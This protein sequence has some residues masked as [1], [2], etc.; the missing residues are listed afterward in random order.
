MPV[1]RSLSTLRHSHRMVNA[2]RYLKRRRGKGRSGE[3]WYLQVPVPVDLRPRFGATV[4]RCLRTDS[5]KVARIR[6]DETL[7]EVR[8]M[9][10]AA[11]AE[12]TLDDALAAAR[13]AERA[14]I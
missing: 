5:L 8:A 2:N 10:A 6:R 14:R 12:P 1:K 11:R 3:R 13:R 9:F 4:E 7:P